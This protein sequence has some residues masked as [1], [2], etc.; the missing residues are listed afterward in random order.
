M[1][2]E[3][4]VL[5][6]GVL[7]HRDDAIASGFGIRAAHV[8]ERAGTEKPCRTG[9]PAGLAHIL[10]R[11]DCQVPIGAVRHGVAKTAEQELSCRCHRA[12]ARCVPSKVTL[13]HRRESTP[14]AQRSSGAR[15]PPRPRGVANRQRPVAWQT[16]SQFVRVLALSDGRWFIFPPKTRFPSPKLLTITD[17]LSVS[18][19]LF[20]HADGTGRHAAGSGPDCPLKHTA[21]AGRAVP[22][23][24]QWRF[25]RSLAVRSNRPQ[26]QPCEPLPSRSV[27]TIRG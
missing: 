10:P 11:R 7:H 9:C 20:L 2:N 23:V 12:G 26:A 14:P 25:T 13:R 3:R 24:G 4:I 5:E 21:R 18:D 27:P 19:G 17:N 6:V 8:I 16:L 1:G 22:S 15:S